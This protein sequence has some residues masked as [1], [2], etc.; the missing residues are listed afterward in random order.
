MSTKSKSKKKPKKSEEQA[1]PEAVPAAAPPAEEHKPEPHPDECPDCQ[2]L[3]LEGGS[4][5]GPRCK[6][7]EGTGW[8]P[9]TPNAPK[10]GFMIP[11][12]QQAPEYHEPKPGEVIEADFT[13]EE[14]PKPDPKTCEACGGAGS[15]EVPNG[16]GKKKTV[17]KVPCDQCNGTGKKPDENPPA[18]PAPAAATVVDPP[19]SNA[20]AA[21]PLKEAVDTAV[22]EI[23][24]RAAARLD[25]TKAY[26]SPESIAKYDAL[27]IRLINASEI[28][29][30]QLEGEYI[31]AHSE[32]S[33]RKKAWEAKVSE[34][35]ELVKTRRDGRGKPQQGTLFPEPDEETAQGKTHSPDWDKAPDDW[36]PAVPAAV[37]DRPK[38]PEDLSWKEIPLAELVKKFG[39]SQKAADILAGFGLDTLGKVTDYTNPNANGW[40]NKLT[41]IK[42]FGPKKLEEWEAA[43]EAF[44]K[45]RNANGPRTGSQD[46]GP[47]VN[48]SG[49]ESGSPGGGDGSGS[50]PADPV[51]SA[52][53]EPSPP[54]EC[55]SR[56]EPAE[57]FDDSGD[58]D[59][60]ADAKPKRSR[61]KPK[62]DKARERKDRP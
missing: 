50:S 55:E 41:D 58:A 52:D 11:G 48:G 18:D 24:R 13:V 45:D 54:A 35:F 32:A 43:T 17:V 23:E 20:A 61:K 29:V 59:G 40:C 5:N 34:H 1:P 16:K 53:A 30:S 42:G 31:A 22:K 38:E 47:S 49:G 3:G 25:E 21:E 57:D 60:D 33:R 56:D 2:G 27:T 26:D 37:A 19:A 12:G 6:T 14:N 8:K 36:K 10:P 46:S 9:G 4:I 28:E 44:W 62:K 39:L 15:H 51:A 7:C